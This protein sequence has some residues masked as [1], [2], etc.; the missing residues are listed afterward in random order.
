MNPDTLD[1][2]I[3][4]KDRRSQSQNSPKPTVSDLSWSSSSNIASICSGLLSTAS[5]GWILAKPRRNSA[6]EMALFWSTSSASKSSFAQTTTEVRSQRVNG[7]SSDGLKNIRVRRQ[8]RT[9]KLKTCGWSAP[10]GW[11]ST[12]CSQQAL[13]TPHSRSFHRRRNP[14][15]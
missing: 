2:G 12:R 7:S 3:S 13:R 1:L 11:H 14:R 10:R 6:L 9:T 8:Q 15:P 4:S 5:T